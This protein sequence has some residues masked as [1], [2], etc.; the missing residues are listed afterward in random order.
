MVIANIPAQ[1]S[2]LLTGFERV[3]RARLD[4]AAFYWQDDRKVAFQQRLTS[5][6]RVVFQARL[7]SMAEKSQ[8]ISALSRL[9]AQQIDPTLCASAAQSALYAKC[10][11]VTGMVGEFPE[12]QGIMGGYYYPINPAEELA[13]R[14]IALAIREHYQPQG[15]GDSLPSSTLGAILAL[16]DKLDT[17]VG[18]FGI[19][20]APTG[21]KDPF[22]LRRAALGIIRI[23]MAPQAQEWRL[24]LRNILAYAYGLYTANQ[25]TC[26]AVQAID[27]LMAFF[28]GRLSAHLKADGIEYDLI[29]AVQS[30]EM[31]DL[32]DVVERIHALAQF[33]KQSVCPILIQANKRIVNL[34][35]K[36]IG[37]SSTNE[38]LHLNPTLLTEPAEQHLYKSLS[39]VQNVVAQVVAKRDYVQALQ[40]LAGLR[41]PIDQF[42]ND[43]LVMDPRLE[44]R[45]N[46]LALL[47]EVRH[48]FGLVA[49]ISRL[50]Q[51]D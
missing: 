43:I 40:L 7:G 26:S 19:D 12:L 8:R 1:P 45:L 17:L 3:L 48:S 49:D 33:K 37:E 5:L 50:T 44:I 34:L 36:S 15:A 47:R 22:A 11:L 21:A 41:D 32:A 13:D 51:P 25:L 31:D 39:A 20:L 23:L 18:Y 42:F 9:L 10:D 24:S 14:A 16:A 46:R 6:E 4:D 28:Y 35:E 38:A 2:V 29:E 27:A 30:R